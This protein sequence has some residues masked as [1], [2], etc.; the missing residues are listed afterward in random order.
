MGSGRYMDTL[1]RIRLRQA[2][3]IRPWKS[4]SA[5][6][7]RN[8]QGPSSSHNAAAPL[9]GVGTL[10]R[11]IEDKLPIFHCWLFENQ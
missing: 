8:P 2:F 5:M 10:H 11:Y 6:T 4:P 7:H 3:G 9:D 1:A